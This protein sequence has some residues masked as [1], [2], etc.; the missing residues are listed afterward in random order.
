[1]PRSFAEARVLRGVHALGLGEDASHL[2]VDLR[3][4]AILLAA[5]VRAQLRPIERHH[6]DPQ[7]PR[8]GSQPQ[9]LDE[10]PGQRLLMLLAEAADGGMVGCLVRGEHAEGG[11]LPTA[12]LDLPA[13]ALAS[14]VGVEQQ[15][16]QHGRLVGRPP[17]AVLPV[18]GVER[19]EIHLA[20]R[21][22]HEPGEMVLGKL[23][24][25]A[26]G[27]QEVL[28]TV[29]RQGA[30]GHRRHLGATPPPPPACHPTPSARSR[31]CVR[32]PQVWGKSDEY[33]HYTDPGPRPLFPEARA[34]SFIMCPIWYRCMRLRPVPHGSVI[35]IHSV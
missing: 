14:A 3:A 27:H 13:R 22:Q 25:E 8:R 4:R 23:V 17:P 31:G 26:R 24:P 16:D 18:G 6:A 20:H 10:E 9:H 19:R 7:Q 34:R 30:R 29:A 5:G 32:Q 35:D 21:V 28:V 15:R 1:M 11:V 12:S 33:R 2:R